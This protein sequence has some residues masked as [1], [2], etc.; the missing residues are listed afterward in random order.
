MDVIEYAAA[1][2]QYSSTE[3]IIRYLSKCDDG[4]YN[5]DFVESQGGL[6][7]LCFEEK[8]LHRTHHIDDCDHENDILEESVNLASL[9]TM[10]KQKSSILALQLEKE[11][12]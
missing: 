9:P 2:V 6:C 3:A 11:L 7:Y 1:K 5:H 8:H 10:I 4:F 12:G